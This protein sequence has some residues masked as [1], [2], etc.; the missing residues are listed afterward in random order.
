MKKRARMRLKGYQSRMA[1]KAKLPET[2][3][4]DGYLDFTTVTKLVTNDVSW[5]DTEMN[6]RQQ[7]AA[8]GCLPVPAEGT[9]Y[10]GRDGRKIFVKNIKIRGSITWSKEE[11][12]TTG[13]VQEYVRLIVVKDTRCN[14]VEISGEDVIGPGTGSDGNASLLGDASIMALTNPN[15]WGRY[16]V[17][18]DKILRIT[19]LSVFNDGT[20]GS[21]QGYYLPFKFNIKANCEVNFDSPVGAVGSIVD[22]AYHL[23]AASSNG[24]GDVKI[25]YVAR[26]AFIG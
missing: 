21:Q 4:V 8:Y 6:P 14:G 9:S 26:T 10:S 20:D 25:S 3:Y 19:P 16:Q 18:K 13:P 15:G 24:T 23:L 1:I 12:L 17:I 5:A 7:T 22:N 2:K 11:S